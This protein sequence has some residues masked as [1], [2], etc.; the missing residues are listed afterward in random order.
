MAQ[1]VG[2]T[3][4]FLFYFLNPVVEIRK[5]RGKTSYEAGFGRRGTQEDGG[6]PVHISYC[7]S[8]GSIT[9]FLL[10]FFLTKPIA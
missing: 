5:R 2:F 4:F 8:L 9:A 7:S 6:L 3:F 10:F 1:L